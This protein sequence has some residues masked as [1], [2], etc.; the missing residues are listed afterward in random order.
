MRV[1]FSHS[2]FA[3]G[4]NS[5]GRCYAVVEFYGTIQLYSI[6]NDRCYRGP[7]FAGWGLLSPLD[8]Y[9]EWF[10]PVEPIGLPEAPL[11]ISPESYRS[12]LRG[13]QERFKRQGDQAFGR[14]API[15]VEITSKPASTPVGTLNP[16]APVGTPR[17]GFD[18]VTWTFPKAGGK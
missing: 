13:W 15:D 17:T 18:A 6:L 1:P 7:E 5:T 10:K 16:P 3:K 2:V 12:G 11:H 8:D 9:K 4:N 14:E